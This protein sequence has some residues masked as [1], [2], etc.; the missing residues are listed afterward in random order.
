MRQ[1]KNNIL[2]LVQGRQIQVIKLCG[3]NSLLIRT[4]LA[5]AN[6]QISDLGNGD[7]DQGHTC[8][9]LQNTGSFTEPH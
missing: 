1:K 3:Q 5:D 7:L 6:V 9:V 8:T 2:K 4:P